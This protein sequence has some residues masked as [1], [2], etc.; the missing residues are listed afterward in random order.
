MNLSVLI[1]SA[2]LCGISESYV[3]QQM[4]EIETATNGLGCLDKLHHFKPDAAV[5]DLEMLWGG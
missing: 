2:E 5:I 1:A 3:G 4:F